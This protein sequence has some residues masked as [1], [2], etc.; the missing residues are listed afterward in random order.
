VPRVRVT[1]WGGYRER[2]IERHVAME[3]DRHYDRIAEILFDLFKRYRYDRLVVAGHKE[4]FAKFVDHLHEDL[5]KR[6]AGHFAIDLHTATADEVRARALDMVREFDGD[7]KRKLVELV[8]NN[9]GPAGLGVLGLEK[10]LEALG[11][12]EVQTLLIGESVSAPGRRCSNCGYLGTG[13]RAECPQ[14][15]NKLTAVEDV[16][17]DAARQ[18]IME[19]STVRFVNDSADPQGQFRAGGNIGAVLRYR[20]EARPPM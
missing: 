4:A 12:K 17:D 15:A 11:K 20:S 13:D 1:D 16:V 3:A 14:C 19:N 7:E 5:R 6:V 8:L 2:Q 10:T 9:A 18:A